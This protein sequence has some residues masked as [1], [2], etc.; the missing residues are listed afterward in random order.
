MKTK[1]F[2]ITSLAIIL[3]T[4]HSNVN[5]QTEPFSKTVLNEKA[6]AGNYRLAHPFE[7]IYGPDNYL[8]ITE[9][10]GRVLRVDTGTGVRQIILDIRAQVTAN[11]TRNAGGAATSV[12][13]NGL[14]GMALH[15]NFN[16]GTNQDSIFIAYSYNSTSIRIARYRYN[17]GASPSLTGATTLI[18][19]LPAGG[20][21]STG[22]LI[23]GGDGKLYY[24]CGD[25]G[26]NQFGNACV[27]IRSQDVITSS[28]L[29][30][31]NYTNY[32]GK[33]LRMNLD[34]SIP[35]DNPIF[36]S[37]RSH[38][39]SIGHRNPQGLVWEKAPSDGSTAVTLV[40]NG[41]LFSS[42]HGPRTDDEVNIIESGKNYGWPYIAGDT[43]NVNYSY[44]NLS[45]SGSCNAGSYNENYVPS[46]ATITTEL[47]APASVKSNFRKPIMSLYPSCGTQ[48]TTTCDAGGTNWIKFATVA[49]SSIDY[50]NI[51]AGVGIPNWYPS[52]IVPTLRE[53][54]VYRIKLNTDRDGVT[55]DT[56]PYFRDTNRY[57]D[58][59]FSSD[60]LKMF[61]ITDSIGT[62]SGPSGTSNSSLTNRGAIL[63]Y[64]FTG[65][66]LPLGD[67]NRVTP[68]RDYV[69]NV[70]PNPA[71][72]ILN[73]NLERAVT[74]P[75]RYE[76]Y[77]VTGRR[78]FSDVSSKTTFTIDVANLK[79]GVYVIRMFN[80]YGLE[81]KT[82]K[83]IL[84]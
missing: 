17:G 44:V 58:M 73:I 29:S 21:H 54:V 51:N 27:A 59:A 64:R 12:G 11:I 28:Q 70:Y 40:S 8:Y 6:G 47:N 66:V 19:G 45:S 9:K 65:S 62:T 52:L 13:Q 41:K 39:Y 38:I 79:R 1:F 72:Q 48:T 56:I 78:L 30:A 24:A 31:S 36:S 80:G 26:N 16:K 34:G 32:S 53:G 5:A 42:E 76:L 18:E 60:G 46:G 82:E 14:L 7:I 81:V 84:K 22:R 74:K 15:P 10:L 4:F 43:D 77:D 23:I 20:D 3:T 83:V 37:V 75:I 55:G 49:P 63:V 69:I 57:R 71:S 61:I 68:N 50:Y 67:G 33:I 25:L 35:A 2:G